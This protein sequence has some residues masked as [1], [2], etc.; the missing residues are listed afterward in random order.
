MNV[1]NLKLV[2][3]EFLNS[4]RLSEL[5]FENEGSFTKKYQTIIFEDD[6]KEVT[7]NFK[8]YC[9]GII[10]EEDG[11]YWTPSTSE[12]EITETEVTIEE[13]FIDGELVKLNNDV[14]SKLEK[15]IEKEIE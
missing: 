4:E 8:V 9:D 7:I 12:V 15:L 11:D 1:D 14:L 5:I 13:V 10:N 6:D 3:G 2:D